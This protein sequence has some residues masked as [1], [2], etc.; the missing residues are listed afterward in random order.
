MCV[1]VG[2]CVCVQHKTLAFF[3]RNSITQLEHEPH[4]VQRTAPPQGCAFQTCCEM[5]WSLLATSLL[6]L[7]PFLPSA[8]YLSEFLSPHFSRKKKKKT[9]TFSV[10]VFEPSLFG[11]ADASLHLVHLLTFGLHVCQK[12]HLV[13]FV[14]NATI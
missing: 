12:P 4:I 1:C 9:H 14:C 13:G 5:G 8:E 10:T 7:V 6:T 2:V 11:P 3:V